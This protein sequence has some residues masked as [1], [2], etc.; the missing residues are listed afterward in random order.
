MTS[1][2]WESVSADGGWFW[3]DAAQKSETVLYP[4]SDDDI[5]LNQE[6]IKVRESIP[7]I[8]PL[9]KAIRLKLFLDIV[10]SSFADIT[11]GYYRMFPWRISLCFVSFCFEAK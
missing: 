1:L 8:G 10:P 7:H 6:I 3:A 4:E 2:Y 11:R 9:A 5:H